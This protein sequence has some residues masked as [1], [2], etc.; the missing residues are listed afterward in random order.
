MTE[1]VVPAGVRQMPLARYL[2]RA[3]PILPGHALRAALKGGDVKV[4]G[5][6]SGGD[7]LVSGG[8]RVAVDLPESRLT[9]EL[10]V[11]FCAG[12]LLAVEKPAALPVDVDEDGI[13]EDT[14]LR[15]ARREHP[16]A[17]LTHRLDAGTGGVMI[18]AL[19]D[20]A[21]RALLGAFRVHAV[22]K[23]YQCVVR[24]RFPPGE[25]ALTHYLVK[26]GRDS[27]VRAYDAP[28]PGALTARL[29]ARAL[30][31]SDA[32]SLVEVD[33]LTGRT[34]QIRV[35]LAR[36]GHPIAGDDKYGDRAF[37]KARGRSMPMLWCVSLTYEDD[38]F[39]SQPPWGESDL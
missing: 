31:R 28:R 23:R 15:R 4:N 21:E 39:T 34:H 8:D 14:L 9:G 3:Y 27:I 29:T 11:L 37:N 17:R 20:E 1:H 13:G 10:T 35:Q 38:T 22:G 33:L 32:A 19:T 7:G 6:R 36:F 24:G 5:A 18:L 30:K 12:G 2:K 25:V 26:H 16:T